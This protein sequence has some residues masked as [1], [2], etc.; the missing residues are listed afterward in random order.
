MMCLRTSC[1]PRP[2]ALVTSLLLSLTFVMAST[3]AH[4][5]ETKNVKALTLAHEQWRAGRLAD[6]PLVTLRLPA[7]ADPRLAPIGK[8]VMT[9]TVS[10]V[11]SRM[12]GGCSLTAHQGQAKPCR[13]RCIA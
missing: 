7:F 13:Y 6:E 2:H 8:A 3:A 11:P 12:S 9:A 4:A 10:A 5:A 1:W